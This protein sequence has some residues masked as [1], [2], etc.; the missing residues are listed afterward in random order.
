MKKVFFRCNSPCVHS[1]ITVFYWKKK[2]SKVLNGDV[3]GTST[4]IVAGRP[5]NQMMGRSADVRRTSVILV[6]L[7]SSQKH[8]KLTLTG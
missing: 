1:S 7:N 2:Y 8:I 4:D 3:H 5:G 6:F